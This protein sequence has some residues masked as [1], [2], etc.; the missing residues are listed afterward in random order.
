MQTNADI[1]LTVKL[2]VKHT[3]GYNRLTPFGTVLFFTIHIKGMKITKQ[4]MDIQMLRWCS[5]SNHLLQKEHLEMY[6]IFL[7][8]NVDQ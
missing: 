5:L 3:I 4:K 8:R 7:H 2:C 1:L 6:D